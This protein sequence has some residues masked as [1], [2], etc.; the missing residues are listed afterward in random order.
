MLVLLREIA[1]TASS[2]YAFIGSQ[3]LVVYDY[4]AVEHKSVVVDGAE[5]LF[6]EI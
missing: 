5:D 6:V 2:E 3:E 1:Q 4:P